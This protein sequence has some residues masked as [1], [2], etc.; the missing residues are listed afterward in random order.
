MQLKQLL[1]PGAINLGHF[2]LRSNIFLK[3]AEMHE[4]FHCFYLV[5][6]LIPDLC[7]KAEKSIDLI[8]HCL[9]TD[10]SKACRREITFLLHVWLPKQ[11]QKESRG[12]DEEKLVNSDEDIK[13][14]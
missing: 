6:R 4:S 7:F 5:L 8:R 13:L 3:E 10:N 2:S 9:D 14:T 1:S 12:R 11:R